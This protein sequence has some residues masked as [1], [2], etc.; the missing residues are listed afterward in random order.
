MPVMQVVRPA[1]PYDFCR[2]L[3]GE[4]GKARDINAMSALMRD[5]EEVCRLESDFEFGE[6]SSLSYPGDARRKLR[7]VQ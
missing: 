3:S 5:L 7:R 2:Q 1:L 4:G 6:K